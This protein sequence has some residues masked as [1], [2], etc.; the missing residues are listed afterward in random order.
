MLVDVLILQCLILLCLPLLVFV[1]LMLPSLPSTF[2]PFVHEGICVFGR[3]AT[4]EVT[5]FRE[6]WVE[7]SE[8]N[9]DVVTEL[10]KLSNEINVHLDQ[11]R[12]EA[13]HLPSW[14]G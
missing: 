5:R 11:Q 12:E 4:V 7:C 6:A 2:A 10:T 8:R 3:K 1:P 13:L 14:W 9:P